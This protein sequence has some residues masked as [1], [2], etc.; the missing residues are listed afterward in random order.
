MNEIMQEILQK[1]EYNNTEFIIAANGSSMI[2]T[3]V[4]GDRIHIN[5]KDKEFA[6]GDLLFGREENG[7]LIIHRVVQIH[8][9]LVT[10]GDNVPLQTER[11]VEALG[12][13]TRVQKTPRSI[14]RRIWLYGKKIFA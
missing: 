8:P 2:P 7:S 5:P 14:F 11:I 1:T 4:K 6:I 3:V 9:E 13:V 10:K 12:K